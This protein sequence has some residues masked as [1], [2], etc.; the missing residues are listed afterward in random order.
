MLCKF[1]TQLVCRKGISLPPVVQC[2]STGLRLLSSSPWYY[3]C[4]ESQVTTASRTSCN[5]NTFQIIYKFPFIRL[6]RAVCRVKIYQTLL[7]SLAVPG[8]GYLAYVGYVNTNVFAT[9]VIV[10]GF[11]CVMLYVMGGIFQRIVGHIYYNTG[12]DLVKVSHLTFWGGRKDIEI[13]T[14]DI[15][16]LSDTGDNP[17]DIYVH[18]LRYSQSNFSLYLCLRFGGIVDYQTFYH[19][20]GHPEPEEQIKVESKQKQ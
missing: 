17:T 7:S 9:A 19:V 20:F 6:A 5:E 2:S 14:T 18:L 10:N 4:K 16:P 15:V 8:T 12:S 11:A 13:P 3:R 1:L